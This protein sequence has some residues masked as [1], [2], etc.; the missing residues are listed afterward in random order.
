MKK[1]NS[2]KLVLKK[3]NIIELN[4][5]QLKSVVG[6]NTTIMEGILAVN[7]QTNP[8]SMYSMFCPA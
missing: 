4:S 7:Q 3:T 1:I 5:D 8:R 6:G 2:K